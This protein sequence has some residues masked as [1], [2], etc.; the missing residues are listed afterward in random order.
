[1]RPILALSLVLTLF[2][3]ANA[4][5]A[6]PTHRGH[7]VVRA[8]HRMI[9]APP[10]PY[11]QYGATRYNSFGEPYFGASQGYAPGEKERFL[12]SVLSPY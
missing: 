12:E 8:D 5:T 2:G 1:M 4:A 6:R 11:I 10:R 9:Y 3:S 7:T